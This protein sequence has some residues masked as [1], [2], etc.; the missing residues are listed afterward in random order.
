MNNMIITLKDVLKRREIIF[1]YE[2]SKQNLSDFLTEFNLHHIDYIKVSLKC[3]P[4][5]DNKGI[6][7]SGQLTASVT[8]ICVVTSAPVLQTIH[9]PLSIH[10]MPNGQDNVPHNCTDIQETELNF[11]DDYDIETLEN[12]QINI[13]DLV[14]EHFSLALLPYPR[15]ANANFTGYTVGNLS[16]NEKKHFEKNVA[17]IKQGKQPLAENPFA[18]L[19]KLKETLCS[20]DKNFSEID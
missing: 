17:L 9:E 2:F 4:I 11:F 20:V 13:F 19:V 6:A 18:S 16:D 3:V 10:F 5:S 1:D 14:R 8:H 15:V 7:L 12:G